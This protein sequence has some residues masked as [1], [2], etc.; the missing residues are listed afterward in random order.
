[1]QKTKKYT[2]MKYT[3]AYQLVNFDLFSSN[4]FLKVCQ[5]TIL[6]KGMPKSTH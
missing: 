6:I 4:F 1:M 3:E 5:Y 2:K